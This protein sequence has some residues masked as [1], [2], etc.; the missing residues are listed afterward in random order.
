MKKLETNRLILREWRDTDIPIF[1]QMNL[2]P[3]VMEFFPAC[4]SEEETKSLVALNREHFAK[5]G[6]GKFAVELK[7][8]QEFIGFVGLSIPPFEAHF[9]P[10]V[11]IGWRIAAKHHKKG[12][13][14]EAAKKTL[15]FAFN[16][17][18]LEEVVSFTV[19]NNKASRRVME[20]IGMTHNLQ[21]DFHHPK[22]AKDHPFSWHV[23]YRKKKSS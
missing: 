11:E 18:K 14:T 20:K 3:K 5:H 12:F 9:T 10:A 1:V 15:E 19:P 16:E 4:L 7:E 17:L 13:A 8:N 23:L 6:Y 2:D 21:D 22:L